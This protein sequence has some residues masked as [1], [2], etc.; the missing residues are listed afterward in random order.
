MV[1]GSQDPLLEWA[2]RESGSDLAML[3]Q[4]SGDGV[5]RL[6][7]GKAMLAGI[8]LLDPD[9]QRYNEPSAIGLSGMR[10]LLMV[11]WAKRRQ[12]LLLPGNNPL[13]IMGLSDLQ[14]PISALHIVS[15]M[16][17]RQDYLAVCCNK[18]GLIA[19]RLTGHRMLH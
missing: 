12:G 17:G 9:T 18:R 13:N 7:D 6:L 1:A 5:R 2:I 3:C 15:P 16:L 8:H 11:H 14:R 19:Q 4:G 10:D